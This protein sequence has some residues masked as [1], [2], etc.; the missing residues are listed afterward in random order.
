MGRCDSAY[1]PGATRERGTWDPERSR[2]KGWVPGSM[3]RIAPERQLMSAACAVFVVALSAG[4]LRF[5]NPP[6]FVN[7]LGAHQPALPCFA[8]SAF[9]APPG[10]PLAAMFAIG[11][12][13][14]LAMRDRSREPLR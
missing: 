7:C 1:R 5:A 14:L 6:Y 10:L 3:L 9:R 11:K 4:G 12:G 2:Q 8:A 13:G